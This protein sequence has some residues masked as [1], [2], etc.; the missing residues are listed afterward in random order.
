VTLAVTV[1]ICV[2]IVIFGLYFQINF[3]ARSVTQGP[4]LLTMLGIAGTFLGIAIGLYY[5][6]PNNVTSSIPGLIGGI[7][8]SVWASFTGILFAILLKVR[9]ALAKEEN[10]EIGDKSDVEVLVEQLHAIQQAI[11][12]D[13]DSTVV[14]Q[15]KL[16]RAE[17]NYRLDALK[18]T[19]TELLER[20]PNSKFE[21]SATPE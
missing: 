11:A 16:A 14:A 20:L 21:G 1:V 5:F 9:Y 17:I 10:E 6:D 19:Q 18:R 7:R 2:I 15:L 13:D 4:A 12:R 3:S 8:T